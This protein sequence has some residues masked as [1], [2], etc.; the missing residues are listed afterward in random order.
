MQ[1]NTSDQLNAVMLHIQNP[2]CRLTHYSKCLRK[3][4]IQRLAFCQA[5]FEFFGLSSQ[6]CIRQLLHTGA[7]GFD[8]IYDRCDSF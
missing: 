8:L 5:L 1:D 2:F 3:N 6:F 4:I 7:E